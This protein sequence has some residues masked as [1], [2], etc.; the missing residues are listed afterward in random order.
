[1]P[2]PERSAIHEKEFPLPPAVLA[3][4]VAPHRPRRGGRLSV[5]PAGGL[6]QR[7]LSHL[8]R[9]FHLHGLRL[10]DR[11]FAGVCR[12]ARQEKGRRLTPAAAAYIKQPI[13]KSTA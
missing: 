13:S 1:M 11:S 3:S 2:Q 10:G 4:P 9:S 7:R 12:Q 6:R 5:L 8:L